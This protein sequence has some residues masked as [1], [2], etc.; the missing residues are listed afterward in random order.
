[1]PNI[2]NGACNCGAVRI[3][4]RGEPIR[5]G[6]CHC[7]TCRKE[8]GS[9]FMTFAVW[10]RSAVKITGITQ[11]WIQTT[12]HRHFCPTCGSTL[13]A[14]ND[15]DNEIELRI[16]C[17]DTAPSEF[18]PEYELWI[19]RRERWMSSITGAAQHRENRS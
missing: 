1:M 18:T 5:V 11:S 9:A 15:S 8:T 12:D 17:L 10:D 7:M 13:F 14:T 2:Q 3:E 19:A 4:A 16:G 6:L